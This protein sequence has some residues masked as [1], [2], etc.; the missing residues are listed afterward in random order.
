MSIVA[1]ASTKLYVSTE[2]FPAGSASANLILSDY[3]TGNTWV[4]VGNIESIGEFGNS[5]DVVKFD[6]IQSARVYKL[7]GAVDA[8]TLTLECAHDPTDLGQTELREASTQTVMRAFKVV[9]PDPLNATGTGTTYY[10]RGLVM[11]ARTK[12]GKASDVIITSFDTEVN[13]QVLEVAATAGA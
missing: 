4:A 2:T 5:A 8:G 11:S 10:F 7:K 13:S 1:T 12:L 6:T 9:L 3:T